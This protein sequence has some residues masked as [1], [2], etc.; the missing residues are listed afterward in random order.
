MTTTETIEL[1]CHAQHG[2]GA[3]S[4]TPR[5]D[6]I[7]GNGIHGACE[8]FEFARQLEREL[9]AANKRLAEFAPRKPWRNNGSTNEDIVK[10]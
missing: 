7:Q 10:P 4:D 5:T 1:R 6:A 2:P 9:N 8:A 3:V